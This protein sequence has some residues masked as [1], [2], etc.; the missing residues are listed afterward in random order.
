[1]TQ[2]TFKSLKANCFCHFHVPFFTKKGTWKSVHV[3]FF[4]FFNKNSHFADFEQ[5][6]FKNSHFSGFGQVKKCFDDFEQAKKA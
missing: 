4:I 5:V 6:V 1:M 3:P 2:D